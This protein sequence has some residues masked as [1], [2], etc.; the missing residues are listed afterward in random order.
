VEDFWFPGV[1]TQKCAGVGP[2]SCTR[3]RMLLNEKV[4]A[5]FGSSALRGSG[6]SP[7]YVEALDWLNEVGEGSG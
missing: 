4:G 5:L 1:R 2:K 6:G 3:E 7:Y